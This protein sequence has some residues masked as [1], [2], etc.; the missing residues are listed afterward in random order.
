M[1]DWKLT[2]AECLFALSHLAWFYVAWAVWSF[3]RTRSRK[4]FALRTTLALAFI[5]MRFVEPNWIVRHET[6][7][8]VGAPAR[9]VLVSDMHLGAYKNARFV[10]RVARRVNRE[11]AD[12]LLIS[13]DFLYSA[14]EPLDALFAPLKHVDK[15]VF[16]VFGNHDRH[17]LAGSRNALVQLAIVKEALMR[18]GVRIIENELVECGGVTIAG[19]GDRWSARD[20]L[21]HVRAYRGE[22]PLLMLTHNPDTALEIRQSRV[23][24]VLAGHTHGGQLRIPWLYRKVIPVKGPFDRGLHPPIAEGAPRVFVTSGLGETVLP[25]RAFNPPVIDVLALH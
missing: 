8:A 22:R 14:R 7:V 18:A 2:A 24:L 5:W 11:R 4:T 9:I 19:V 6:S 16:A 23:G 3:R 25:M 15:P 20:E 1:A 21:A 17:E 12:C 13:G 10:R